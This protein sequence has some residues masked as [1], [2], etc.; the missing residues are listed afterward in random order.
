MNFGGG[1]GSAPAHLNQGGG[2][3]VGF[4]K[5]TC[6]NTDLYISGEPSI[7]TKVFLLLFMFLGHTSQCSEGHRV[8]H[9]EQP[10]LAT[11]KCS[12][13]LLLQSYEL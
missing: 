9:G 4:T 6:E 8:P 7:Y 10:R 3:L 5:I 1:L 13:V 2:I 11:Y 12:T